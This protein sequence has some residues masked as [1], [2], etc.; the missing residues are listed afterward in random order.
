MRS[1]IRA[2]ATSGNGQSTRQIIKITTSAIVVVLAANSLAQ[3]FTQCAMEPRNPITEGCN[4]ATGCTDTC[5][6]TFYDEA[7]CLVNPISSCL[8]SIQ[9]QTDT[10][11]TYNCV[12]GGTCYCPSNVP[13]INVSYVTVDRE[14]CTG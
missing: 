10:V 11:K 2:D 6:R 3:W 1:R 8:K 4:Y 12:A 13:A 14:R 7:V 5:Q 9:S